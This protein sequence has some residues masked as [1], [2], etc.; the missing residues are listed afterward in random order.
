MRNIEDNRMADTGM[1]RNVQVRLDVRIC[2]QL[3]H[4]ARNEHLGSKEFA[5]KLVRRKELLNGLPCS[6]L[7]RPF[8]EKSY[9][10]SADQ[11]ANPFRF[12]TTH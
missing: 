2:M 8:Q 3:I 12:E 9:T 7:R 1:D 11:D 4:T 5:N 10:I 6:S